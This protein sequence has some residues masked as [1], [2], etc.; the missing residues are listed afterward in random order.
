VQSIERGI[1]TSTRLQRLFPHLT[2]NLPDIQQVVHPLVQG[3]AHQPAGGA[4]LVRQPGAGALPAVAS[5]STAC[6][7][8]TAV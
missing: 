6:T 3:L 7:G 5:V 2:G 1:A 8:L 4:L